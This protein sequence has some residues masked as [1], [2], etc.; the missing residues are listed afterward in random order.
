VTARAAHVCTPHAITTAMLRDGSRSSA[1]ERC[2]CGET[3][4]WILTAGGDVVTL[5]ERRRK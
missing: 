3:R 5:D 1:R 4:T 2:A